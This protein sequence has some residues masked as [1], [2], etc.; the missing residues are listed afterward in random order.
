MVKD[1]TRP[2]SL[3]AR[4]TATTRLLVVEDD[5]DIADF[6]RAYFRAS[7]YDVVHADPSSPDEAFDAV[8]ETKPDAVL[9]DLWLRGW[10]GLQL[11]RRLRSHDEYDLTPVIVLTA[12]ISARPRAEPIATGIDGFVPK[13]FGA[14]ELAAL[15][16]AQI[17]EARRLAEEGAL[18]PRS[19]ALAPAVLDA[20]IAAELEVAATAGEPLAFALVTLRSLRELRTALGTD[21]LA[22]LVRQLVEEMR[23]S[24]PE[25]AAL[26]RTDTDELVVLLPGLAADA[27]GAAVEHALGGLRGPRSL[28]GGGEV[29]AD[30]VAGIAAWPEHAGDAEGLFMAAD[31]AL[32]D[33]LDG[34]TGPVVLAR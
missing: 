15:V 21:G 32:A 29:R 8:R 33:A 6:L 30:P 13:P 14:D 34:T 31:A 20:R 10:S 3:A 24:L 28:P 1:S 16:S 18:D 27:A 23:P 11:Y 22:W 19:G 4:L 2:G 9:L 7:G 5:A 12:D 25:T 17:A 26:G